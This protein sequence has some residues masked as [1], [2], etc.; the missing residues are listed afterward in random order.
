MVGLG[1]WGATAMT[2]ETE[3]VCL[4][5][6]RSGKFETGQGTCALICMD[7][8]GNPRKNG[9]HHAMKVHK[10]LAYTIVKAV[11]LKP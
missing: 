7:Q 3:A 4:V 10:D 11:G 5:L 6:C 2:L 1:H 8:L 9:C